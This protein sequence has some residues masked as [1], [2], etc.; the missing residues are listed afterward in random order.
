[1]CWFKRLATAVRTDAESAV[2]VS[3]DETTLLKVHVRDA[4]EAVQRKRVAYA[5]LAAESTRLG[6]ERARARADCERFERDASLA[7]NGERR[8]LA[9]YA[10]RLLLRR[11]QVVDSVD[12]RLAQVAKEQRE[13]EIVLARQ[14]A[15]LEELRGRV[16]GYLSDWEADH[17]AA[18]AEPVTDEQVELEL[19][20]RLKQASGAPAE[21][22]RESA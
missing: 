21:E 18:T 14:Q 5:E 1:M 22:K 15:A 12:R 17:F 10:L 2:G 19:L 13:L 8:D 9:R 20:R 4:E 11:Q 7:L 3:G 6:A 16:Q